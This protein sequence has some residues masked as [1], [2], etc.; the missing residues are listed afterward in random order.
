[1]FSR[2]PRG[3]RL[4]TAGVALAALVFGFTF[5]GQDTHSSPLALAAAQATAYRVSVDAVPQA[6]LATQELQAQSLARHKQA[7]AAQEMQYVAAVKA[8]QLSNFLNA[9]AEQKHQA[10]ATVVPASQPV[11]AGAGSWSAVAMCEEG[12]A[13]D[14]NYG[15]YGIKEWNGFDGYPTA[16]SAPQSVQLQWEQE[17][18]GAPPDESGGCH[19]Y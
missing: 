11:T 3:L 4:C 10:A 6:P 15:Y 14:P 13:N 1:M 16:G 9:V 19:S 12:G 8:A 18:V 2:T 5:V 17:N 7:V